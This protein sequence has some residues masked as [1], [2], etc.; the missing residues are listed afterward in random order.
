VSKNL[1][2]HGLPDVP[3]TML[4]PPTWTPCDETCPNCNAKLVNVV[5][6]VASSVLRGGTGVGRYTGCPACPY[7]GPCEYVADVATH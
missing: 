5:V 2:D 4:Q 6:H 3:V 7:A 1:R